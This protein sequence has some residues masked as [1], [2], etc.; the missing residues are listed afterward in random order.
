M[1]EFCFFPLPSSSPPPVAA[2]EGLPLNDD[3]ELYAE[4]VALTEVHECP[5]GN[6]T[7]QS[8]VS[9]LPVG[10]GY[11]HA[12]TAGL[13]G[14]WEVDPS[15][16]S[17]GRHGD[18]SARTESVEVDTVR[19]DTGTRE[20]DTDMNVDV[21]MQ[22]SQLVSHREH[23]RTPVVQEAV[24]KLMRLRVHQETGTGRGHRGVV[25][26]CIKEAMVEFGESSDSL[27]HLTKHM[28]HGGQR[29]Y[30]CSSV[31]SGGVS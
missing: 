12:I 7:F 4:L 28:Q 29:T 22:F 13:D 26:E 31:C 14:T 30:V 25:S 19:D 17:D 10:V 3:G 20:R 21:N 15:G 24:T 1:D 6:V 8:L 27:Y 11:S 18:T 9:E 5:L 23:T 16:G 2:E